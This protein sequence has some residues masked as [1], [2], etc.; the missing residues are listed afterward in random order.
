MMM[1]MEITVSS[2]DDDDDFEVNDASDIKWGG[3][4]GDG[5]VGDDEG[6]ASGDEDEDACDS[7]ED[8][9]DD[10]SLLPI[11]F[12]QNEVM[13]C[14]RHHQRVTNTVGKHN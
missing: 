14:V 1:M 13:L 2:C 11:S 7:D 8:E 10:A 4:G 12:C 9:A 5:D 6:N 3:N